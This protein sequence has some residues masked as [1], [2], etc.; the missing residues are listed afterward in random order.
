MSMSSHI[1]SLKR[2]HQDLDDLIHSAEKAPGVDD[3]ELARLKKE[4]LRIKDE[5]SRAMT[6][7]S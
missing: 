6:A 1:E 5:I 7:A 2:K 4:K 3:L